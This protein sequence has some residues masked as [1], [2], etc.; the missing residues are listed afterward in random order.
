MKKIINIIGIIVGCILIGYILID[1]ILPSNKYDSSLTISTQ[2][3]MPVD[4]FNS[5]SIALDMSTDSLWSQA[6]KV[7]TDGDYKTALVMFSS[8]EKKG[9]KSADLYYNIGNAYYKL[10]GYNAYAILYY[11]RALKYDPSFED[12]RNNL[13][14]A[15]NTTLDKIEKVPDFVLVTWMKTVRD[16]MS[17]NS[18]AYLCLT[19]LALTL[20][21]L[22]EMRYGRRLAVRKWSF[23]LAIVALV[24]SIICFSFSYS[25]KNKISSESE[26]IIVNPVS[27]VKSSPSAGSTS[28]FV[29]H[30]GTKVEIIE[31]LGNWTRVELEDGRQGWISVD[32]MRV[33]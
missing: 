17:S 28:L 10:N 20:L 5:D 2:D 18:W 6:V 32:E 31:D 14:L 15:K 26:A 19:L 8:L 25:L 13:S 21:F 23:S 12:A 1:V 29:I 30:E 24:L 22:L 4:A 11:E 3:K 33:I 9:Y 7:Y 16:K 27:A